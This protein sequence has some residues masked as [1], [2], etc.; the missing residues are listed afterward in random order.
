M[1]KGKFMIEVAEMPNTLD[2]ARQYAKEHISA[3]EGWGHG[4][5]HNVWVDDD[6]QVCIQYADGCWWHYHMENGELKWW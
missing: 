3:V 6:G 5:L 1:E 4:E 2:L